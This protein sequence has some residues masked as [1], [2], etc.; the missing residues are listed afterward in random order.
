LRP[1][2]WQNVPDRQLPSEL[3]DGNDIVPRRVDGRLQL[4]AIRT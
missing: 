2:A 1:V 3:R 4:P